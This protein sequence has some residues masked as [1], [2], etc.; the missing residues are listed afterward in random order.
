ML[1]SEDMAGRPIPPEVYRPW[2]ASTV[3]LTLHDRGIEHIYT[4]CCD[5]IYNLIQILTHTGSI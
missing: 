4:V 1:D 5:Q 3:L 2:I